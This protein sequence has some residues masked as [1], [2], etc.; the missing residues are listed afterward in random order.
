MERATSTDRISS[1]HR[2]PLLAS[3]RT[4]KD[5]QGAVQRKSAAM[6]S[7]AGAIAGGRRSLSAPSPRH[8]LATGPAARVRADP[9]LRQGEFQMRDG[10]ASTRGNVG[11]RRC[12]DSRALRRCRL[13]FYRSFEMRDRLGMPVGQIHQQRA[14][15]CS[16]RESDRARVEEPPRSAISRM[17][18]GP[19]LCGGIAKLH[20]RE[21]EISFARDSRPGPQ[22]ASYASIASASRFRRPARCRDSDMPS[23]RPDFARW[24]REI[25]FPHPDRHRC[26]S[27][28]AHPASR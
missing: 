22:C 4:R 7:V 26:D 27:R 9:V 1:S 14:R 5:R 3:R 6:G 17:R 19:A 21:H 8:R 11:Q 25:A 28:S 20:V 23:R 16:W 15:G 12:Q 18:I 24:C 13:T 2:S 10:L